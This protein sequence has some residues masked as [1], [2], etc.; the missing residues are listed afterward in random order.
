[1]DILT[2]VPELNVERPTGMDINRLIQLE[3]LADEHA[4]DAWVVANGPEEYTTEEPAANLRYSNTARVSQPGLL[5]QTLRSKHAPTDHLRPA[6]IPSRRVAREYDVVH[7]EGVGLAPLIADFRDT[8]VVWSLVD[9]PSY[10]KRRLY[11]YTTSTVRTVVHFLEWKVAGRIEARYG[12]AAE[13]IHVVSEPEARYLNQRHSGV[14]AVSIPVALPDSFTNHSRSTASTNTVVVLGNRNFEDIR[15]GIRTYLYPVLDDVSRC[16]DD[17]RVILLGQGSMD[18]PEANQDIVEQPGWVEDYGDTIADA[19]VAVVT[20]PVGSGIKNRTVQALALGV[21][22]VGTRYAFEGLDIDP[23]S[24][25][26]EIS[27]PPELFAA[28]ETVLNDEQMRETMSKRGR[29]FATENFARER[30]VRSWS[31]LYESVA[32]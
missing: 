14:S 6:N 15:E 10:R 7:V 21:P 23:D 5:L 19:S 27:S 22:V 18:V 16:F 3:G 28:L 31:D 12:P 11:E 26:R 2:I 30:I 13:A 29:A 8:P 4:V 1:M 32:D 9:A 20:D 17:I 25:G 24:I